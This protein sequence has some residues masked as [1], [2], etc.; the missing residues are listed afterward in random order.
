MKA[1]VFTQYGPP[2]GLELKDVPKPVPKDDELLIR[3]HASSINSWDWEFLNGTPFIN[4]LMFGLFRPKPT[5]QILGADIAGTVEAIGKRVTRFQAGDAVFGDLW[6]NWGGFA[7]YACAHETAV[8]P[9]PAN[10]TFEAAAAIPQAGVLALQGLRKGEPLQPGQAVLINGAGGGVGTIAIQLARLS[11]TEV[12]GVDAS[13]K[14]DVIRSL[15]ADHVIDYRQ[16]DFTKTGRRY[17]LIIDCQNFRSMLDNRRAL[18]PGG[19]Y[20]MIG[21]SI[22]RVYQLWLL[23]LLAPLTREDRRLCLVAEGANK[24]LAQLRDLIET[25]RLVPVIDKT[26]ELSEV[27][28]AL[29]Y[30][31]EGRHKGKIAVTCLDP[32][33]APRSDRP[34]TEC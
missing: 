33:R 25:G 10:V 26:Y 30:F 4:R 19:T 21:G 15:G 34:G 20:A 24:G 32:D 7:E 31:G 5:K 3:V 2:D 28:E 14:L 18:K 12:T 27:P 9:K 11:G 8:E 29:R 6:D 17:D 1:I 13:H 22:P 16:Q 23:N